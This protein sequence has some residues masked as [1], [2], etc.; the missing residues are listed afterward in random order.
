MI[1]I[2]NG[3]HCQTSAI[4]M[5]LIGQVEIQSGC[6]APSPKIPVSSPLNRPYSGL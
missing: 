2:M 1:S 5:E 4:T 3:V 6:A